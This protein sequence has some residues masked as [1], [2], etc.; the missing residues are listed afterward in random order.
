MACAS[1]INYCAS[2][3][4]D[5]LQTPKTCENFIKLCK[6][7]YYDGTIFHRSIRNFVVSGTG[8]CGYR[9]LTD[10]VGDIQETSRLIPAL[11]QIPCSRPCVA[12]VGSSG[13]SSASN[14]L[15]GPSVFAQ[16]DLGS[17]RSLS[18]PQHMPVGN[19]SS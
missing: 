13:V 15:A 5:I 2:W 1:A 4:W 9:C 8:W 10:D 18:S 16:E 17:E 3:C 7:Q 11:F 6:K 19:L 14:P 12:R